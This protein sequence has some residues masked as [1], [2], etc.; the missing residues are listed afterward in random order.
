MT[1]TA[2][3]RAL[4]LD[5]VVYSFRGAK[6]ARQA[7]RQVKQAPRLNGHL[8]PPASVNYKG[9]RR[10]AGF[11]FAQG[12]VAHACDGQDANDVFMSLGYEPADG[13]S[14]EILQATAKPYECKAIT[15]FWR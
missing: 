2:F 15:S 12:V 10:T 4:C 13:E 1:S 11:K 5:C 8:V 6:Q 3:L 9:K 14:F 7:V